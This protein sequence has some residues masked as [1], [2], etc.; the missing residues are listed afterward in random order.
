VIR[1]ITEPI[2]YFVTFLANAD[3]ENRSISA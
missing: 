1:A 2:A 3:R